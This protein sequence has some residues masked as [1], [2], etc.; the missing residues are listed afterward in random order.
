MRFEQ[1]HIGIVVPL[2][3]EF[4][5]LFKCI[6]DFCEI[7]LESETGN[8][9]YLFS[10][11]PRDSTAAYNCVAVSAGEMGPE[12]AGLVTQRLVLRWN[13]ITVVMLGIA[14]GIDDSVRLGDVVVGIQA[15]LYLQDSK[16]VPRK[17][18]KRSGFEFRFGGKVY[19][20]AST[21]IN[22]ARHFDKVHA[23]LHDNWRE[24]CKAR[25]ARLLPRKPID[26]MTAQ[27]VLRAEPLLTE[28]HIATGPTVGAAKDFIQWLK[29]RDRK[30]VALDME[31]AGLMKAV[32]EEMPIRPTLIL[33]GV[34]DYGDERKAR[35]DRLGQGVFRKYA[36]CNA[37][38]ILFRFVDASAFLRDRPNQPG[39]SLQHARPWNVSLERNAYFSGRASILSNLRTRFLSETLRHP[40]T[41]VIAGL[42]GIGKTQTAVEYAYRHRTDYAA[43]LWTRAESRLGLTSSFLEIARALQLTEREDS[44]AEQQVRL[45]KEWLKN[46]RGWLLIFDNVDSPDIL[47]D[48]WPS[49]AE[50]HVLITSR[51]QLFDKLGVSSAVEL[52]AM[53][54]QDAQSFFVKRIGLRGTP[55]EL[56]A[57]QALG[58]ELGYLPLALEQAGAFIK[59]HKAT[60]EGYLVS[61][62]ERKLELLGKSRPVTGDYP[63]SV[64]TTWSINFREIET[65]S[66]AAADVLHISALLH[67]D[68]IPLHL[69]AHGAPELGRVLS[70]KLAG[71]RHNPVAVDEVFEPLLRYSIVRHNAGSRTYS[72]HRLVQEVLKDRMS[73]HAQR[74]WTKRLA[75]ALD[76]TF[77]SEDYRH[78]ADCD[79]LILQVRAVARAIAEWDVP[80]RPGAE[81]LNRAGRYLHERGQYHD[82][83][84][85]LKQ[86][87]DLKMRT[88]PHDANKVADCLNDL[89]ELYRNT[90]NLIISETY[91]RRALRIRQKRKDRQSKRLFAD[92][93]SDMSH[94]YI[95][96]GEFSRA[97]M[98]CERAFHLREAL[99]KQTDPDLAASLN[100]LG[101]IYYAL[102]KYSESEPLQLKSLAMR[103]REL[104]SDHP[105]VARNLNNL[106]LLQTAQGKY[107]EAERIL[108]ESLAIRESALGNR[109]PDISA[110][111]NSLGQL[112]GAM[113]DYQAALGL[114]ER[115]LA[116]REE[117]LG[118]EHPDTGTSLNN[119]SATYAELG[120]YSES[121]SLQLRSLEIRKKVLG[122]SH[123]Y[124]AYNFSNLGRLE[125]LRGNLAK[126]ERL[127]KRALSI[128]EGSLG[129][130]HPEIASTLGGLAGIYVD[131]GRNVEAEKMYKRLVQIMKKVLPLEHPA[132]QSKLIEYISLLRKMGLKI[133]ASTIEREIV[134]LP[135]KNGGEDVAKKTERES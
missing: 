79:G 8:Y 44:T 13:P 72:I 78:W 97:R 77:P 104:G 32:Y 83:E 10:L 125:H 76:R 6:K 37:I 133:R 108:T 89:A 74:V 70:A 91:Y 130:G 101:F 66:P 27:D 85:L 60:L 16:A 120:K 94:L 2:K 12:K 96:R 128:R 118:A 25:F 93:L 17:G 81:V 109:H 67:P 22:F 115:A 64:L 132:L 57:A 48:F 56:S 40:A 26:A 116:I 46:N 58:E 28:G 68:D 34:S 111:L 3:E 90:G 7:E 49:G 86:S 119:L 106:G 35:I 87:L 95:A 38:Q 14:A 50:G 134:I 31:T 47:T 126:A 19:P 80:S 20:A 92:T 61:Y 45:V 124:V 123:P 51:K 121:E 4:D 29:T 53:A 65:I 21:L 122:L 41:E 113:G 63:L 105:Y 73:L 55:S 52:E 15:D 62:R 43:I 102:G 88:W 30:Y 131:Q 100:N 1:T 18:H 54:A 107:A 36:I 129:A 127:Y 117:L 110:S 39:A 23:K 42:G 71:V 84:I 9:Y 24:E 103:K 69:I 99:L 135:T 82:A 114:H 59:A 75:S 98:L 33:R 5:A 112:R 11:R